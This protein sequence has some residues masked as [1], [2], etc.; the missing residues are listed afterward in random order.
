MVNFL[1][2]TKNT[3]PVVQKTAHTVALMSVFIIFEYF[4]V[5][6]CEAWDSFFHSGEVFTVSPRFHGDCQ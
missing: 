1:W 4:G 6:R 3:I 5:L 2:S